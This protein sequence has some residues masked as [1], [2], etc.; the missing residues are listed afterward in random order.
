MGRPNH[1]A[2]E[3]DGDLNLGESMAEER[4]GRLACG[5]HG[6]A[7]GGG[8]DH[9]CPPSGLGLMSWGKEQAGWGGED[10]GRSRLGWGR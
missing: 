10:L 2:G 7:R 4:R 5:G 3:D 9:T 8:R 6:G 1:T